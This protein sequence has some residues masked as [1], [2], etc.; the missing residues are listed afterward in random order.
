[1]TS[2][3]GSADVL[4]AL[5]ARID[6]SPEQVAECLE[7]TGIG[8]MFAPA[9]HPAMK[10]AAGPRREIG[11][12]TVFNILGPLTNPAGATAQVL[13]VAE[14][15]LAEKMAQVLGRL[16][17]EHALVVHGEDGFDEVSVS[18]P[19]LVCELVEGEPPALPGDARGA[20]PGARRGAGRAGRLAG[21]E[22]RRP[23]RVLSG[24]RG[25]LR[26]FTLL[27]AAAGLVAGDRAASLAEGVALAAEA[28][29]SGAARECAGA[30]CQRQQLVRL[31]GVSLLHGGWRPANDAARAGGWE[32]TT[33][34]FYGEASTSP[35]TEGRECPAARCTRS[36][37]E[38]PSG[39]VRRGRPVPGRNAMTE[40]SIL[41][42]IV[43][44]KKEELP[45]RQQKE[46]MESL[47]RRIRRLVEQQEGRGEQWSLKRAILEGPRGPLNGGKRIQ[48]IAEIKKASPSKGR[49][50]S[51][52]ERDGLPRAYV[53]SGATAIS[54]ADRGEALPG[55]HQAP[56][57]DAQHARWLLSGRPAVAPAQGLPLRP[58]PDLGV[59]R[60]RRRRRPPHRR[61]PLRRPDCAT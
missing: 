42:R 48:I 4:E 61:H 2:R 15:A 58:L 47:Q 60:V 31:E 43:A 9:F 16:G 21:R 14:P 6:L 26:D 27:N 37:G 49:I 59:A 11:V 57:G 5:G 52:L 18:A 7:R 56:P 10:F 32:S 8:F 29:D 50:I 25:P 45:Y 13:G 46:P 19:T 3:C 44:D 55:R 34:R 30:L 41:D 22:R 38:P 24:E 51:D 39:D 35:M 23:A 28:I 54:V 20:R 40:E 36:G 53:H 12:R 33:Q 17:C 1:M